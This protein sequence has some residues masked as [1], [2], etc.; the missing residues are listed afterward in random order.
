MLNFHFI[1]LTAGGFA[2]TLPR[3]AAT[4]R[5]N[6]FRSSVGRRKLTETAAFRQ[7]PPE[8]NGIFQCFTLSV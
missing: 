2:G 5:E 1:P 6:N 8:I 7:I 4:C 3:T